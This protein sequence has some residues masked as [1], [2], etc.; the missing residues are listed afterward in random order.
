VLPWDL[1]STIFLEAVSFFD[2]SIFHDDIK[3]RLKLQFS[4]VFES[5]SFDYYVVKSTKPKGSFWSD[6][7]PNV[8]LSVFTKTSSN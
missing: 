7:A 8:T 1:Y 4:D 3:F 5:D 6:F 2:Q